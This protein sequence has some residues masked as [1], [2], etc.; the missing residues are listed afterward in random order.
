MTST[1]FVYVDVCSK[2]ANVEQELGR[3]PLECFKLMGK[4]DLAFTNE[5]FVHFVYTAK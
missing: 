3:R 5:V 2:D 4:V 1:I